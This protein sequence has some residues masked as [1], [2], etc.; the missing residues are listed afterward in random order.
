MRKL[1][2][3]VVLMLAS[4][5]VHAQVVPNLLAPSSK[6]LGFTLLS[7]ESSLGVG[8]IILTAKIAMAGENITAAAP[9]TGPFT[10]PC[11]LKDGDLIM[12]VKLIAERLKM[13]E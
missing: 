2:A 4:V 11:G 9:D 1:I 7:E 3:F 6:S 5:S 10:V 12:N 13:K 8:S